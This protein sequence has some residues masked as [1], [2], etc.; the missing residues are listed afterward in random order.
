[1]VCH[2]CCTRA[3]RL[4]TP[5]YTESLPTALQRIEEHLEHL[6]RLRPALWTQSEQRQS[7]TVFLAAQADFTKPGARGS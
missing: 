2:F 3:T 7:P 4:I 5:R 1:M 6:V